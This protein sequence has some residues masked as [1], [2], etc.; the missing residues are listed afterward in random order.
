MRERAAADAKKIKLKEHNEYQYLLSLGLI[1]SSSILAPAAEI[2]VWVTGVDP[3]NSNTYYNIQQGRNPT[4]WVATASNVIA[5][6]QENNAPID[7]SS[8]ISP[9]GFSAPQKHDVYNTYLSLYN[10]YSGGLA[11]N[12]YRYWLGHHG[13]YSLSGYNPRKDETGTNV[14]DTPARLG[15][16]YE[17]YY[18]DAKQVKSVAWSWGE[19]SADYKT[20][21]YYTSDISK[22]IYQ[23]L[24]MGNAVVLDIKNSVHAVTLW[25]ATF[26]TETNL[27]KTVWV[28]DSSGWAFNKYSMTE[29]S[30]A[31]SGDKMVL[32]GNYYDTTINNAHFLGI[33]STDTMNFVKSGLS[34]PEP[35][36]FG[37]LA[38]I[39][40]LG[41]AGTRRNRR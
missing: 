1:A 11:S 3:N 20:P 28:T 16:F 41:L 22:A 9:E 29:T 21:N 15:G 17:S 7:S 27:M 36:A 34:I 8:A 32:E 2:T 40:V 23:A 5:H 31:I 30:V 12:Y 10:D 39:F 33:N 19:A 4:C 26:D 38:G 14:L 25:G 13:G 6:W 18:T 35:S 24:A 37:L